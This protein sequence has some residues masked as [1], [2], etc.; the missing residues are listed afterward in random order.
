MSDF[1]AILC[2][3]RRL[4]AALR[5]LSLDMIEEGLDK[6]SQVVKERREDENKKKAAQ[7]ERQQK[8]EQYLQMLREDNIDPAE[9]AALASGTSTG[10]TKTTRA[11]R[12]PKYVYKDEN[13][14]ECT[15]TGQG[16]QPVAIR[17]AIAKGATLESFL[18]QQ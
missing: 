4:N 13:G 9:V 18:I 8:V 16:R 5:D 15:W 7:A 12:P 10:E 14:D 11:K 3:S 17:D 2:N 6:L 1:V